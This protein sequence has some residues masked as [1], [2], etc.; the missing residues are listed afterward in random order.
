[1]MMMTTEILT[2]IKDVAEAVVE[3]VVEAT[4]TSKI[5]AEVRTVIA[6]ESQKPTTMLVVRM[7]I[8]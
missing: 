4:M 7:I 5:E 1:M 6:V 2:T 8:Y 3:A